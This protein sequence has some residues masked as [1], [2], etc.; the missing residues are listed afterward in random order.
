MK[1][2]KVCGKEKELTEFFVAR[3]NKDGRENKCAECRKSI[4]NQQYLIAHPEFAAEEKA[5][6]E[7]PEGYK[8]CSYCKN[9]KLLKD[10][11]KDLKRS[12][13]LRSNCIS[14]VNEQN[15]N[16]FKNSDRKSKTEDALREKSSLAPEGYKYCRIC[17]NYK[18][19]NEFYKGPGIDGLR[20]NCINCHAQDG[21]NRYE[22]E[23]KG[24]EKFRNR[25]KREHLKRQYNITPA[26]YE[27]ILENQNYCCGRCGRNISQ[28]K[29]SLAVDH[30][31]SC[32]SGEQSCGKCIRGLLCQ[33][34]NTGIGLLGDNLEGLIKAVDYLNKGYV[35]IELL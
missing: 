2:C 1:I 20:S 24:T 26:D 8:Y 34:C 23:Y 18:K 31:H 35:I 4:K 14:C 28:F 30:D 22:E 29:N 16:A 32:C 7:T 25:V 5:R 17:D 15:N 19:I 9:Y 6:K 10:Y 13:G 21:A 11:Y 3:T 27:K 12:D 33:P